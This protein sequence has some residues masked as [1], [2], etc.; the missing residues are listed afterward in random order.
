M[1]KIVVKLNCTIIFRIEINENSKAAWGLRPSECLEKSKL[2]FA[3][4]KEF[5]LL[6]H[7]AVAKASDSRELNRDCLDTFNYDRF[8]TGRGN[9]TANVTFS[10][11]SL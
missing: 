4:R 11:A 5:F 10:I 2:Y 9:T 6:Q 1:A 7:K 3:L 8:S